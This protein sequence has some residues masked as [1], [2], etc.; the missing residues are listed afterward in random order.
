MKHPRYAPTV[1][2]AAETP[3]AAC[4]VQCTFFHFLICFCILNN[5]CDTFWFKTSCKG[6]TIKIQAQ[7]NMRLGLLV[8]VQL[9][10]FLKFSTLRRRVVQV[11]PRLLHPQ[12]K[13]CQYPLDRKI[14]IDPQGHPEH[15]MKIKLS[16]P[17]EIEPR[18]SCCTAIS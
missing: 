14:R 1:R 18:F 3:A 13:N 2:T 10:S 5:E 16:S 15:D 9:H 6:T 8:E 17:L 4:F 12:A 7:C 11:I